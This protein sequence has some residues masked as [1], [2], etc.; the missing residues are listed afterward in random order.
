MSK[1]KEVKYRIAA[2]LLMTT[3]AV[4][5]VT[6]NTNG[7]CIGDHIFTALGLP[8]WSNGTHYPAIVGSIIIL[9]GIGLL[10]STLQK[11][12]WMWLWT[13]VIAALVILNLVATMGA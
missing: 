9:I 7:F 13:A 4:L 12:V 10:N 2:I 5:G 3:G 6:W 11:K 1:S 8:S